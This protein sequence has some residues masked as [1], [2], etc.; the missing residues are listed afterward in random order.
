MTARRAGDHDRALLQPGP[1]PPA[2]LLLKNRLATIDRRYAGRMVLLAAIHLAALCLLASF[3]VEPAARAAFVLAWGLLNCCWL[4]LLRRPLTAAALSLA[5]IVILIELS[6]FKHGVLMMTATFVD[7][8]LIDLATLSFVLVTTPD[9][10]W[11]IAA[12]AVLATLTCQPS[13]GMMLIRNEKVA[14]STTIRSTKVAVIIS[15]PCLNCDSTIRMTI[16]A[17]ESAAAVAG[18]R[19]TASQK[20]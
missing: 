16:S 13:P 20:P 19:S 18:R 14:R 5:L 2:V 15:T 7:V 3:E 4:A 9:L 11:K 10:F 8:M 12:A 17:S 1:M 6:R